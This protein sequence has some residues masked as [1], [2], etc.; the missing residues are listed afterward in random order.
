MIVRAHQQR[1]KLKR[2]GNVAGFN[3]WSLA[4]LAGC[5][6]LLAVFNPGS[7]I[8]AAFLGA[9]SWNEFRGRRQL[10]R[11][12]PRGPRTLGWNQVAFSLMI[13]GY[14]ALQIYQA[15][16]GPGVYQQ[17]IAQHPEIADM[18][19]PMQDLMQQLTVLVY[20]VFF[21]V[22]VGLQGLTAL[23]Y[24]TRQGTLK[25]HLEQTPDW[26]LDL[27]RVQASAA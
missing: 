18:L 26:V 11:L 3:A 9:L 20:A 7:L 22:G 15:I 14:C 24:F 19:A 13:A 17:D 6:A 21:F 10:L 8:A 23:Y 2:A 12:D 5:S 1:K 16:A 4:I 27:E 25:N